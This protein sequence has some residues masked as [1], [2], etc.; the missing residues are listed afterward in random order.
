MDQASYAHQQPGIA[1]LLMSLAQCNAMIS[2]MDEN[3]YER[4]WCSVEALMIHTLR[5]AYGKHIWYEHRIDRSTGREVLQ[6]GPRSLEVDLAQTEL[7]LEADRPQLVFLER[8]T[9]LL[10]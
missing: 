10:R 7:S 6:E 4:S 3:Y 8:Q 9:R 1:A 2:L 5:K